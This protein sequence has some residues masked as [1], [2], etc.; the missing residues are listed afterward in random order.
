MADIIDLDALVRPNKQVKLNNVVYSV[1]GDLPLEIFLRINH[2]GEEET[3]DETKA[4]EMM[5]DAI[6]DLVNWLTPETD[7]SLSKLNIEQA[8]KR[9]GIRGIMQVLN[10]I[11]KED[12]EKKGDD[13][14][15]EPDPQ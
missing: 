5:I 13:P 1:P 2:A 3:E 11:Y 8:V 7:K 15:G 4:M 6:V 14:E 10:V 12:E 9:F